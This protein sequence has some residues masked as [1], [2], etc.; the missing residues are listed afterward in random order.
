MDGGVAAVGVGAGSA[1]AAAARP[2]FLFR[3]GGQKKTKRVKKQTNKQKQEKPADLA[4]AE[5]NQVGRTLGRGIFAIRHWLGSQ[6]DASREAH[7][8]FMKYGKQSWKKSAWN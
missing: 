6:R 3:V 4:R 5:A 1:A 7:N 2:A 8:R